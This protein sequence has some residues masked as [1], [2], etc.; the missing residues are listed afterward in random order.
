MILTTKTLT[1]GLMSLLDRGG[2][3]AKKVAYL[4]VVLASLVWL[5]VGLKWGITA[6]WIT[7][8]SLLLAAVTT[9]YLGGKRI[10]QQ[11]TDE[12]KPGASDQEER[13]WH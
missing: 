5:S 1:D 10:A 2:W 12:T 7:V 9:G 13:P 8:Y 11:G 6:N 4:L 3:Q